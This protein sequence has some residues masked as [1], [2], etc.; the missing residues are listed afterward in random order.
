[1]G[2][3]ATDQ[4]GEESDAWLMRDQ[5]FSEAGMM[6]FAFAALPG[7]AV[8]KT[9]VRK[10]EYPAQASIFSAA[11][12]ADCGI[13]TLPNCRMRFLPSFCFSSSLRLRVTSP[14]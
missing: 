1:M 13:S 4:I 5:A 11:R 6:A 9:V 8:C 2:R 3:S 12:N 10:R 7:Q 14:P